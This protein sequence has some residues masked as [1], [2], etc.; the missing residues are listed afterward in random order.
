MTTTKKLDHI[1]TQALVHVS[2][3]AP[4]F[5]IIGNHE[6]EL[7]IISIKIYCQFSSTVLC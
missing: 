5:Y 2:I 4:G 1:E 6:L 7:S 3:H